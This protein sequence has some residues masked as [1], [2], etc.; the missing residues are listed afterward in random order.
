MTTLPIFSVNNP[1]DPGATHERLASLANGGEVLNGANPQADAR[2]MADI[3][4]AP[5][6][7]AIGNPGY[8]TNLKGEPVDMPNDSNLLPPNYRAQ[9]DAFEA[10]IREAISLMKLQRENYRADGGIGNLQDMSAMDTACGFLKHYLLPYA[11]RQFDLWLAS[12]S[13]KDGKQ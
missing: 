7:V 6:L 8:T 3:A 11:N 5:P 2:L 1:Q 10:G 4:N 13:G 9:A 12:K